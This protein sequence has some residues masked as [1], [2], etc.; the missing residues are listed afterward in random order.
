MRIVWE[1]KAWQIIN[2]D[3]G[4]VETD[5]PKYPGTQMEI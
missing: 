2:T 5:T 4:M 1:E 3:F